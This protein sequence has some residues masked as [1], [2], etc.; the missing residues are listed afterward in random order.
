MNK[1]ELDNYIEANKYRIPR[2]AKIGKKEW[3][4][5]VHRVENLEQRVGRE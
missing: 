5:L 1:K 2:I 3:D 4:D